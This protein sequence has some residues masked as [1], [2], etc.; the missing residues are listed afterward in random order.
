MAYDL[1]ITRWKYK[2]TDMNAKIP[3]KQSL[4][5]ILSICC[6]IVPEISKAQSGWTEDECMRYAIEHNSRI[7]NKRLDVK[8]AQA[9][10][11]TAYGSFL[12]S[13]STVGTLGRQLGHSINPQTNQYTSESFW[14]STVG[15][16][17]S[18]P[19]FE[20]FSRVNKL[21]F[22]RLNKKINVLSSRVEENNLA[23]EV[24]EAFYGYCFDKEMHKLAVEQRKLSE[25]YYGQ[26]MEYVDLGMRSLSDLQEVKARLQSDVY[27]ETVKSNNCRLSLLALK[28]LM[29]MGD[30][31]TLSVAVTDEKI[32]TRTYPLSLNELYTASEFALP[33]FHIMKMKEKASRKSLA[34]ANGSFYPSIRME[35]NLN[36][37]YYDTKRNDYGGIFPIREQ[38]HN[39][40]NKYMGVCVSLPLFTGLSHIGT[41]RK[42][43]LRLEQIRNE[44]EQQRL[45]LY[46]GIHDTYLSFRAASQECRLAKE[47]LH[48]DSITWKESEE[49]WKEGMITLFELL[50]KRN[51]YIRAKAEIVRTKL[52]YILK[53]RMIRFYQEGTF[54]H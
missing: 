42:E 29:G 32:G 21:R 49:R 46:K 41:R 38:L 15:L 44:N 22:Y 43:K 35:F 50:E 48:A 28:E 26:M 14:E 17:V 47:Q 11:V 20:G 25:Y 31:D 39:N 34:M 52:Q 12:P 18:F 9:D 13:V 23:F 1:H 2:R 33:E 51:Q 40:M 36:T 45:S 4:L 24:L 10:M 19:L 5:L 54:L 16:T 8:I 27:Q 53:G 7:R 6:L 3:I 30:S 37:G